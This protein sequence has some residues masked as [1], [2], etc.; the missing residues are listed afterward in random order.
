RLPELLFPPG[1]PYHHPVIGSHEDLQAASVEDVKSFFT[2]WYVPNNASLVVAG[3]FDP[4]NVRATIEH[5]FGWIPPG[6]ALRTPATSEVAKLWKVVRETIEDNVNLLKTVMAWV[7]PPRFTPG[8]AEL[9]LIAEV[10]H[11]GKAS[12]LY[13]ALVYDKALAQ[14]VSATQ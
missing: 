8:D 7:S 11:E 12:R 13:K 5:D 10:L 3:D 6:K 4:A 14:E 2:N 1:Y 9:D